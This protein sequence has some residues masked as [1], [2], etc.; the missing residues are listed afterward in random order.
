MG[1]CLIAALVIG[2]PRL[3]LFIW[4]FAD[5]TRFAATFHA[6][7]ISAGLPV[8]ASG[9]PVLGFLILPWTTIAYVFVAPGGLSTLDWIILAVALLI[10]LSAHG[11]GR[12]AY[13]RRQ[14]S[15]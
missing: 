4:W 14:R 13:G 8:P 6:W 10:D 3:G 11:G 1:C 12:A 7:S 15:R 5:P 9:L 2:A